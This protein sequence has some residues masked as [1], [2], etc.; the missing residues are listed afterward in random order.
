MIQTVNLHKA[1]GGKQVLTGTDIRIEK[2][3]S[4][5][6]IGG[7]GSGKSV[8]LKHIIRLLELNSIRIRW[9]L[10]LGGA[11]RY[12]IFLSSVLAQ[13]LDD[14]GMTLFLR[15]T[16]GVP[17]PVVFGVDVSNISDKQCH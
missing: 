2:G 3:E 8:L 15:I 1:F 6:V 10:F 14:F 5:V 4:M 7:S 17:A 9:P 16:Q 11:F 12:F 13:E